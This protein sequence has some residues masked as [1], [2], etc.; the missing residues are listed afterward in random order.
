MILVGW[1]VWSERLDSDDDLLEV[2]LDDGLM[3]I[4]L[5][6]CSFFRFCFGVLRPKPYGN[7]AP[8][9]RL[10]RYVKTKSSP[11]T[12][13]DSFHIPKSMSF[14][15]LHPPPPRQK[16][17]GEYGWG[18]MGGT[19]FTIDPTDNLVLISM[20]QLAFCLET[21]ENLRKAVREAMGEVKEGEDEGEGEEEEAEEN[22]E[23]EEVHIHK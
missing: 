20:T 7:K 4:S 2:L 14:F 17:T 15:L 16:N 21:E 12:D 22:G 11:H 13:F 3:M 9:I 5:R 6:C 1:F 23:E 19:A 18:G 10:I 8:A